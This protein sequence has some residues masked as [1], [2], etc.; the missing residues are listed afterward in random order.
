MSLFRICSRPECTTTAGCQC[1]KIGYQYPLP[2]ITVIPIAKAIVEAHNKTVRAHNKTVRALKNALTKV[3]L[4]R[5]AIELR[6]AKDERLLKDKL[7]VRD[8]T[9]AELRA[10]LT[11]LEKESAA[12]EGN[13]KDMYQEVIARDATIAELRLALA[14]FRISE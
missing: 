5:D 9:I 11:E 8:A 3:E 7:A 10:K 1:Q 13:A 6:C 14:A 12:H 2:P 4:S